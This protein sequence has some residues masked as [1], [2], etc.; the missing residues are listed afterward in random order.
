MKRI[1]ILPLLIIS[2]LMLVACTTE[3]A[4][5][6]GGAFIGGTQGVV[7]SFEPLS[8]LEEG[9][10]SIFDTENFPLEVIITNKGEETILPGGVALR[11]LGPAQTDFQNI[12]NWQLSNTEDIEKISEF[13]PQGDEE[14][15]SF[16]PNS[17]ATYI[18]EVVGYTDITWNLDYQ[19]DYKTHLIIE[20]VCFKGDPTD[21]KVCTIQENKV[22]SVS[23]APIQV[24]AVA[25][26]TGGKGIVLL[27][28]DVANAGTG[29]STITGQEFDNRFDQ[30][31]YTTDEPEKWEC[32]SGGRENEAR[33]I[34]GKAQIIC[35]LRT[36]LAEDEIYQ[37]TVKL[38]FDYVYKELIQ[39][40]LRVKESAE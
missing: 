39:E 26:D 36:P 21:E 5:T 27:K 28:I 34:E 38:T 33:L 8:I 25:E 20:N 16:T 11:L 31:S 13:N 15:I 29:K 2:L 40:K 22:F 10:Y 9:V 7:A 32:K 35:R 19:Y 24:S 37:R 12:P 4:Q 6:T 18:N 23:G 17:Y 14:V 1:I 30:I 3:D